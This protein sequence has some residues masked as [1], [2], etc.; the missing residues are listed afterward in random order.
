MAISYKPLAALGLS[1]T[2]LGSVGH[3][4]CSNET[5]TDSQPASETAAP[6]EASSPDAATGPATTPAP[7]TSVAGEG[8]GGPGGEGG[9]GEGGVNIAATSVYGLARF[10]VL[11]WLAQSMIRAASITALTPSCIKELWTSKPRTWV[12]MAKA[13][14]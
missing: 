3:A 5:P 13:P 4:A 11:R 9:G 1:T 8:E 12:A 14:L 7:V 2:L 6:E 10:S